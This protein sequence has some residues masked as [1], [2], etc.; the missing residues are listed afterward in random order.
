MNLEGKIALVTGAGRDER[1]I[2]QAICLALADEGAT[3][4]IADNELAFAERPVMVLNSRSQK[5][6][7]LKLDVTDH[8]E[9]LKIVRW[10]IENFSSLDILVNNA[11]VT[12]DQ[13]IGRMSTEQWQMVLDINLTGT[14]NCIRA[15]IRSGIS[16]GGRIVNIASVIGEVGNP[17]QA[18]YAA[19]KA[20]VIA[21]TK[22][23][24]KECAGWEITVN[25]IAPGFI[26]TAMT[27]K[28]PEKKK[29]GMLESIPLGRFGSSKDVA[30]LVAFLCSDDA[31]Y[32]TGQVI[33]VDGGMVM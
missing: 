24:A 11:G 14:F 33:N 15:A 20:G 23:A 17:G 5:A 27:D 32:I 16:K 7:A 13:V 6:H 19:S 12:R 8:D 28:L 4:C 10:I 31:S 18:N 29:N 30:K 21:L 25:A 3:V 22:T 1:G 9:C 2:G 26:D